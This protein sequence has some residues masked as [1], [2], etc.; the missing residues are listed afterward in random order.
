MTEKTL[1]SLQGSAPSALTRFLRRA[2]LKRLEAIEHGR[3]IVSDPSGHFE[4]GGKTAGCDLEAH[5]EIRDFDAYTDI[6][7]AGGMG[8][9]ESYMAGGYRCSN[10]TGLIRIFLRNRDVLNGLDHSWMTALRK[11]LMAAIRRLHRNS[12]RGSRR[13]IAAHYDLGN[14]LFELFLDPTMMY[15][16]AV[17]PRPD[18][19]L[20]EA[21]VH[22]LDLICR[23]LQLTED[24]HVLEIGTGWGGFAIHAASHY[25]C[26]VTTT[27]ISR[28]QY[29]LARTRVATAGVADRVELL[30]RDYRDL[31]GQ[32]DK[33]VSV[34]M[35]EAVGYEYFDDYFT[36]CDT[37]LKPDGLM[38]LQ[39]IT[40][41]DQQYKSAR[42]G[43]D[44]I[45]RYI[46]PG[47][48]LPSN[49][50]IANALTR[51]TSMGIADLHDI[52]ADY[53]RTLA[54]WRERFSANLNRVRA[55]GYDERFVRMWM[56]YLC[57]CEGAFRER[58]IS[59]VQMVLAKGGAHFPRRAF[60]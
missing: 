19:G 10:L 15:S 58:A 22:K 48:C 20:D 27:T 30:L 59:A 41:A 39:A 2:L 6:A 42:R 50:A 56:F 55:L 8:A 57:Y 51:H 9:G 49:T 35:I 7:L 29:E 1:D 37:L 12:R 54:D 43:V 47:G 28:Q 46:F 36:R 24:D 11:P 17:Y 38:L 14:D 16:S 31:E 3:L 5:I 33:L 26:R 44:F 13:N 34:E 23:K 53:A 45:K 40:I 60:H 21:A 25:G 32:Y 52:G 4:F 18:T